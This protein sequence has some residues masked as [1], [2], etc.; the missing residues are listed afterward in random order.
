MV[1]RCC[2]S[3]LQK[4]W[5][6][7]ERLGDNFGEIRPAKGRS[8]GSLQALLLWRT[9]DADESPRHVLVSAMPAEEDTLS[10]GEVLGLGRA[11]L[12]ALPA[13]SLGRSDCKSRCIV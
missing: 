12:S 13:H 1:Q 3:M 11:V 9:T 8:S 2:L 10:A 5:R 7:A 6:D 4:V